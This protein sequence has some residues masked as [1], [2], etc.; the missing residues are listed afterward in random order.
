MVNGEWRMVGGEWEGAGIRN[1]GLGIASKEC[2]LQAA[3]INPAIAVRPE[4]RR[5]GPRS[6]AEW[7]SICGI[8]F[9]QTLMKHE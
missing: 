1:Q 8:S 4:G 2:D 7:E 3:I 9:L 5:Q 6:E